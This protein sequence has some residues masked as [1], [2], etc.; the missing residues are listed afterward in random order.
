MAVQKCLNILIA[1]PEALH[2]DELRVLLI[3]IPEKLRP[4]IL[5]HQND[6]I[7]ER[8][9]RGSEAVAVEIERILVA[10]DDD[11]LLRGGSLLNELENR[12]VMF[13]AEVD[14]PGGVVQL[15][16]RREK[17][18]IPVRREDCRHR[19]HQKL[20]RIGMPPGREFSGSSAHP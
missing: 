10:I 3:Q 4:D 15:A 9:F 12:A 2:D 8:I 19:D 7:L 5:V 16:C 1:A 6:G 14:F 20:K 13:I 17:R 11:V 18:R